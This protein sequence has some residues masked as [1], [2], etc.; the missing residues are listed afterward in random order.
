MAAPAAPAA[1]APR[2]IGLPRARWVG[3]IAVVL[4][5]GAPAGAWLTGARES[6]APAGRAP[7]G[8]NPNSLIHG[9]PLQRARCAHWL[10]ASPADR[11]LAS[12][13]LAATVGAPTEF[14]GVRGT[15][16][17]GPQTYALLDSSC[18]SPIARNFL[19]YQLYIRAAAFRS[20]WAQP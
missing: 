2:R 17:T 9:A 15:A 18:A 13:A 16:L 8:A 5:A 20:A 6:A 1:R 14:R 12:G 11:A 4:A 3:A 19:L 7:A 10:A